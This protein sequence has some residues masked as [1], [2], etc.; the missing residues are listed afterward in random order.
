MKFSELVAYKNNL[1]RMTVSEAEIKAGV[2]IEK[3][4]HLVNSKEFDP[5]GI[6]QAMEI[7]HQEI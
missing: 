2:D 6:K 3:I 5:T 1:S 4:K 7:K